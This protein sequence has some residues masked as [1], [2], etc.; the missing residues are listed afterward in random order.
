MKT[1]NIFFTY[2][3]KGCQRIVTKLQVLEMMTTGKLCPCGNGSILPCN[4]VGMEWLLPRVWKLVWAV[5][6]GK[7][8]PEPE[9]SKIRPAGG[10]SA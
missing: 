3:C 9:P 2:R 7:L 6:R 4:I 1:D 8:A 10:A 5:W